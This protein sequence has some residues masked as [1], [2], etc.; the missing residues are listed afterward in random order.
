MV[1]PDCHRFPSFDPGDPEVEI[2]VSDEGMVTGSARIVLNCGG[3]GQEMKEANFDVEVDLTEEVAE[4]R[5]KHPKCDSLE[6]E[7]T[8]EF[9]D[10]SETSKTKTLKNGQVKVTPIPYRYQRRFYGCA[11]D[12]TVTCG[13]DKDGLDAA[14]H[15]ED[16][17]SAGGMD[18]L[19]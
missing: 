11:V 19:V 18:E 17:T 9:T 12:V 7:E 13:C 16:E 3:C 2:E 5:K 10:R 15:W 1:C 8:S 6:V 4:H 14:G